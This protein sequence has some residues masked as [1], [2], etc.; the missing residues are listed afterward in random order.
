MLDQRLDEAGTVRLYSSYFSS[1]TGIRFF[2]IADWASA[3]LMG[4][5][6][7]LDMILQDFIMS[8]FM[9]EL[10]HQ[11]VHDVIE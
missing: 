1:S 6:E 10:I 3:R 4:V 8:I 7:G 11:L 5:S 2:S 9:S